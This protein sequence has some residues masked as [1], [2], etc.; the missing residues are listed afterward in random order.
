[1]LVKR[2]YGLLAGGAFILA[3]QPARTANYV[4][5]TSG[6]TVNVKDLGAKGDGVSDDTVAIQGAINLL[7]SRGGGILSVPSGTYLLNSY[8][9]SP[10]P[11]FFYNIRVGS[12]VFIQGASGARFLQGPGGRAP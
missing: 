10:H 9:P 5:P 6:Y 3:P 8:S 4:P 11:W 12:N 1:M 2:Y 7:E